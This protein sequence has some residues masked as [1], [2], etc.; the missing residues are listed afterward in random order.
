MLNARSQVPIPLIDLRRRVNLTRDLIR[1][2]LQD[3][4]GPVE[5]KCDFHREWNGCWKVLVEVSGT[6][7]GRLECTLLETPQGGILAWPRPLPERWR[8]ETGIP[9]T[10]GSR[11]TFDSSGALMPFVAPG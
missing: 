9:A 11:W 3:L 10:D 4:L 6:V 8:L 5:V 2:M 1:G 7:S